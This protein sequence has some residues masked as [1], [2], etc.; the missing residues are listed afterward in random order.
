MRTRVSRVADSRT[1]IR[2]EGGG[3]MPPLLVVRHPNS[4]GETMD[5]EF[6]TFL[7]HSLSA[8]YVA[9]NVSLDYSYHLSL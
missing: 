8:S 3:G 4:I 9:N 6:P 5:L 7:V 1:T 2:G